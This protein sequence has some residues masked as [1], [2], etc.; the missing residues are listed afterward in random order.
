M[1]ADGGRR[2]DRTR[3]PDT[4]RGRRDARRR[5]LHSERDSTRVPARGW[6]I[7]LEGPEGAGKTTQAEALAGHLADQGLDVHLTREPGGTWLGERLREVLLA[8]TASARRPTRDGRPAVQRRAPPARHRG[9]PAGARRRSVD[10][11]RPLRRLDAGLPGLWRRRPARAAAGARGGGDRRPPPDLTILLDL[12]VETGLAR[13][14][15]RRDP[16]RA[17][18]RPGLPPPRPGRLPGARRSGAGSIRGRRR[19]RPAA[20]SRPRS[21]PPP[22]ACSVGVNRNSHG[23]HNG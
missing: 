21:R 16:L 23:A 11:V 15:R 6:F 9:H 12:P 1:D 4:R 8:R 5:R 22:T 2:S 7:T 18:I 20:T 19:R 10:P 13:G 14:A 17:A 3:H